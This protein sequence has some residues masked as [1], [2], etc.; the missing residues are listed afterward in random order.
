VWIETP[1]AACY[2]NELLCNN[3]RHGMQLRDPGLI[4]GHC[5]TT[6]VIIQAGDDGQ[7]HSVLRHY[8]PSRRFKPSSNNPA[9]PL[10][11]SSHRQTLQLKSHACNTAGLFAPCIAN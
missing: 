2:S 1:A 5:W 6:G 4:A 11:Q 10:R 8:S 3:N 9:A 7:V